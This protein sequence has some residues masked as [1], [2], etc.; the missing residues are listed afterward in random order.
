MM[1]NYNIVE[2]YVQNVKLKTWDS[3]IDSRDL[4]SSLTLP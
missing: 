1:V 4:I 3:E 2:V